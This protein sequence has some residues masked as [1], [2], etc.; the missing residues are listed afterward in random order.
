VIVF[1]GPR[2]GCGLAGCLSML[3]VATALSVLVLVL[4]GGH[5]FFFAI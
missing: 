4:S 3:V 1:G 2:A 5:V